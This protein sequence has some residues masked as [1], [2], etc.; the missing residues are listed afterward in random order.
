MAKLSTL[1]DK[2]L[3]E[4]T[5]TTEQKASLRALMGA[6]PRPP[7][8]LHPP[9]NLELQAPAAGLVGDRVKWHIIPSGGDRTLTMAAAIKI[10]SDSTFTSKVMTNGKLYIV[11]LE[12]SGAVWMLETLVGGYTLQ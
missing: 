11:Q 2:F 12:Y 4:V 9:E 6:D 7:T 3:R 10:P 8:V 1:I 5:T